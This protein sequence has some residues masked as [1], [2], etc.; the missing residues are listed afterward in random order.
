MESETSN[1]VKAAQED[2]VSRFW[3]SLDELS[4]DQNLDFDKNSIDAQSI[5][6]MIFNILN[7]R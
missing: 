7:G 2:I 6:R 4:I 3:W 5:E 1:C